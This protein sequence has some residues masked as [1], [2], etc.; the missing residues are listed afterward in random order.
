MSTCTKDGPR[1][2]IGKPIITPAAQAALEA[3]GI[4]GVLLLA[5]HLHG[6]WGDLSKEDQLQ[7][8]LALLLGMRL[9][10]SYALLDGGKVSIITEADRSVTTILLPDGY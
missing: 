4:P 9:L 6:D 8:D 7:N 1:F 3:A 10:S 2:P 5:R